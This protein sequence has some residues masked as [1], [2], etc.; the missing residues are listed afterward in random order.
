MSGTYKIK[1][2]DDSSQTGTQDNFASKLEIKYV[3]L[4]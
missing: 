4:T 1:Y 2:S 3:L